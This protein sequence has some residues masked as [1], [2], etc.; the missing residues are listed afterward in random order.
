[1]DE[2]NVQDENGF[3]L[4]MWAAANNQLATVEWLL[5][6]GGDVNLCG[7]QGENALLLA[8]SNGH[9]RVV[10]CLL[11]MGM[12]VNH[13]CHV[14]LIFFFFFFNFVQVEVKENL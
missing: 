1:M 14:S 10:R 6:R 5:E 9:D 7:K 12:D 2:I 13:S 8:S 11:K 4:M 3:S